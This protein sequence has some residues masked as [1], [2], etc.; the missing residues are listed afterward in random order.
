MLIS[1]KAVDA[2]VLLHGVLEWKLQQQLEQ[3]HLH[4]ME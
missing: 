2:L 3:Y 4:P 1:I